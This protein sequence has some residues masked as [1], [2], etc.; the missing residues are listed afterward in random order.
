MP[1]SR[2]MQIC[3][4]L[5]AADTLG[6]I[7]TSTVVVERRH[8]KLDAAAAMPL[9]WYALANML[10]GLCSL[11]LESQQAMFLCS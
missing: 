7:E 9:A 4:A 2:P 1:C 3:H 5:V 10:S 11:L 8:T 6:S